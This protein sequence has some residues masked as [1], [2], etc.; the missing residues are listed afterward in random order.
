MT[1]MR[2]IT[3]DLE[4]QIR[5][6]AAKAGVEP[7]TYITN[8]L[9]QHL[10]QTDREDVSLSNTETDLLQQINLG[11]SEETWQQYH[12]LL[13]KRRSEMLSPVEQ[14]RLI[15]IT[16]EIEIANARRMSALVKLAQYRETSLEVL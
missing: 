4:I 5:Q 7:D 6:A 13:A 1:I 12:L 8:V 10:S 16:D 15:Q 9:E 2:D 3:P 11:L 14:E